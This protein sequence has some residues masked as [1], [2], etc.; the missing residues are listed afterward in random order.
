MNLARYKLLGES[1]QFEIIER[2]GVF[3]AEREEG[4]Y[5]IR[6]YQIEGFYAEIFCHSHFNVI[7]RT[8]AFASVKSLQP[9]LKAMNVDELLA[10]L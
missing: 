4:F 10:A 7:V 3:L 5:T 6:L 8:R 9:Y 1:E 2:N